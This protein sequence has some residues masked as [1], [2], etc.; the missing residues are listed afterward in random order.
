MDQDESPIETV[1]L[2]EG[3]LRVARFTTSITVSGRPTSSQTSR[4]AG[5]EATKALSPAGAHGLG[6]L[7][8]EPLCTYQGSKNAAATLTPAAMA[9]T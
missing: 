2:T 1:C 9:T 8:G 3:R 5:G 7:L 6:D 4:E